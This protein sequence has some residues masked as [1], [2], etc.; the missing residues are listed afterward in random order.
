MAA[1]ATREAVVIFLVIMAVIAAG[2]LLFPYSIGMCGGGVLF[3]LIWAARYDDLSKQERA[4]KDA[5][6]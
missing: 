4:N 1:R 5:G 6:K 2:L 3:A